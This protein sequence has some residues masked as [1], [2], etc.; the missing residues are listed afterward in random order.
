L[1]GSALVSSLTAAGHRVTR[2]VRAASTKRGEAWW[3]PA[4]GVIPLQDLGEVDGA[5]HLAGESI[6]SGRWTPE[7]KQ[8]IRDS[9][10]QGTRV[11]CEAM[12]RLAKPPRVIVCASAIGYYGHRGDEL[13]TEQSASGSGFLAEVCREW[14]AA[15]A[16]AAQAGIRVVHTRFG[17]VLSPAGGALAKM[18][19][20]FR[21]GLGGPLG[22]GRQWVSWVALD[23]VVGAIGAA[24][25]S[26]VLQG[27]VN[28][29]A[30]TPVTNREFTAQLGRALNHP[31]IVP[32][33]AFVLRFALGELAADLLLASTRVEPSK[34]QAARYVF[35]YSTLDQ[36]LRHLLERL[37]RSRG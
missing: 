2:L 3:D 26:P 8:L 31:A 6:A 23:D 34:L 5:V 16:P 29:V 30:P 37:D 28:V 11:L 36:A 24:L 19:P 1:I 9:R 27:P 7:K 17:M 32:A 15:A 33:P 35:R 13:L 12:T 25:S 14:E 21:L 10:V 4:T 22:S 18:L 20:P